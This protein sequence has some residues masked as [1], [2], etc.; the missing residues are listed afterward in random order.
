MTEI[1][2]LIAWAWE[3]GGQVKAE[4]NMGDKQVSKTVPALP[5]LIP[6]GEAVKKMSDY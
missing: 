2:S 1:R 5:Q 6:V 3:V 4:E